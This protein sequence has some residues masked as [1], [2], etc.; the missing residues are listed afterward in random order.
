MTDYSEIDSAIL[1]RIYEHGPQTFTELS[2]ALGSIAD[3]LA[4]PDRFG[5]RDAWRVI[6][7]RLQ[8]MRKAGKIVPDRKTGWRLA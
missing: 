6:D 8:A 3:P 5:A 7:R 2:G 4:R 1:K